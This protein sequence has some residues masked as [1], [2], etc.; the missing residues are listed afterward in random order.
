[1]NCA[2][3]RRDRLTLNRRVLI[4]GCS[5]G[6][7]STLAHHLEKL[8]HCVVHEPGLRVIRGGGPK[9][10]DDRLGFFEK[11]TALSYADLERPVTEDTPTFFDRGL[12]DALSGRAGREK[13]SITTLMPDP[14]PYAQP[15][16]FAPPWPDIFETTE[17][18]PH[19]FEM[20]VDEA[21]RL[22]RHLIELNIETIELPKTNVEERA[23]L[24]LGLVAG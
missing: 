16:F 22:R 4:T 23:Q 24:V 21:L 17:D 8:G 15:V 11:V 5:G 6:G 13:V 19:S 9:P 2:N 3:C 20:A 14:F 18:R 7:K 1:M 12:L 10:W